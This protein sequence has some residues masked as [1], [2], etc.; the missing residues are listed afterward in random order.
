MG[1]SIYFGL[2]G[3]IRNIPAPE[4]GMGFE[5]GNDA[6][7]T[8]LVSGGRS[9]YRAPLTFKTHALS[10][11]TWLGSLQHVIDLYNGNWGS[12]P[13][14]FTDPT[15]DELNALP[16]RWSNGWQ[17]AYQ[18][19]GW[20]KPYVTNVVIQTEDPS[21]YF[22]DRQAIFT[23]AASGTPATSGVLKTRIIRVPGKAYYLAIDATLSGTAGAGFIVR[24]WNDT[25]AVWDTITTVTTLDGSSVLLIP[26]NNTDYSMLELD[27]K[28]PVGSR[29]SLRGLSL[30]TQ[31]HV[32]AGAPSI[33]VGQ[34]VG[35]VQF[36][37]NF[38]GTLDSKVI[39]RIG[40]SID[41]TEVQ[42]VEGRA[43]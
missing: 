39:A 8:A 29:L 4:S 1:S 28:M 42:N 36:S 33:P 40:M 43:L 23:Q 6:E 9:V 30:G 32:A 25:T 15:A 12:G 2:P 21:R 11:R 20:C 7:V 18:A 16:A 27:L 5:N 3:N 13:F 34:G 35:P 19:N 37:G 38:G 17:L 22:T 26:A 31:D 14:Y 24:G 41:L 10:W